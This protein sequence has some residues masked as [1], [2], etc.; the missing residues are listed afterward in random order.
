[1]PIILKRLNFAFDL[2]VGSKKSLLLHEALF[3]TIED[4]IF[5]TEAI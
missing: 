2:E 5:G 3:E 1:M 4:E